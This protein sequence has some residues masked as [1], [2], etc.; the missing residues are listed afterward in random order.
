M[1]MHSV[2]K[3]KYLKDYKLELTFTNNTTK[4][5]D[6]EKHLDA[7]IF[8]ILK[9]MD[10]FKKV[11]INNESGTIEWPNGAD[12]CPDV[13][14]SIGKNMTKPHPHKSN[15]TRMRQRRRSHSKV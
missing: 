3:V 2:K 10:Y 1:I 13:L 9:D 14:Y 12:I 11:Y 15:A 5:V 7:G 4:V 8:L 6:L